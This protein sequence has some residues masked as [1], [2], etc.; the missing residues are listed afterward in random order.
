[1]YLCLLVL[2]YGLP[3]SVL[4]RLNTW[5]LLVVAVAVEIMAAV[6]ALAVFLLLQVYR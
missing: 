4:L 6:L 3:L 2:Q 5:S 1:M